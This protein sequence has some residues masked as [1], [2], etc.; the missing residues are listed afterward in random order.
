MR[1]LCFLFVFLLGGFASAEPK[2]KLENFI[3]AG[4]AKDI[5]IGT[6]KNDNIRAGWA[7][8][9]LDGA[10]GYDRL[11]GEAGRDVFFFNVKTAFDGVDVIEDFYLIEDFIDISSILQAL[12]Y[13]SSKD[14]ISN[15]AQIVVYENDSVL[16]IK[17]P[18]ADNSFVRIAV[19]KGVTDLPQIEEMVRSG[20]LITEP[21]KG[22]DLIKNCTKSKRNFLKDIDPELAKKAEEMQRVF[23][24][25]KENND[26]SLHSLKYRDNSVLYGC[27]TRE[28]NID[29]QL[30][31]DNE[32]IDFSVPN[33]YIT[34][35]RISKS[36]LE[37]YE[38]IWP[39]VSF[40][41]NARDYSPACSINSKDS[42]DYKSIVNV[43]V[44][45][46]RTDDWISK[47]AGKLVLEQTPIYMGQYKKYIVFR[48]IEDK[49]GQRDTLFH[50]IGIFSQ[51]SFITC[52][53]AVSKH[54]NDFNYSSCDIHSFHNTGLTVTINIPVSMI[55]KAPQIQKNVSQ[56][57]NSF[58]Q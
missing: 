16:N 32:T 29:F 45:R 47:L 33:S 34:H 19:I 1:F 42:E 20:V 36:E 44:N 54:K 55:E 21:G 8:D 7:C 40:K 22:R 35:P 46:S 24:Q 38:G 49:I 57:I 56:L 15:F 14:L 37:K 18:Q 31:F 41:I 23:A 9:F 12:K 39:T 13:D 30:K 4:S 50:S 43:F 26:E 17:K 52:A 5:L 53:R 25:Q 28:A 11:E 10:A 6:D 3:N 2:Y 58:I 48:S 27:D 51:P